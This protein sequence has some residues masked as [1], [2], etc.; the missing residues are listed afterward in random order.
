MKPA[1][2]EYVRAET[3]EQ[4]ADLL[5]R[6]GHEARILAGGQSLIAML[7]MRLAQPSVIVDI[8]RIAEL[9]HIGLARPDAINLDAERLVVGAAITQTKLLRFPDLAAMVPLVA[10][11]LPHVG[12]FQTRNKG[13]VCGSLAHADPSSE[14]PLCMA[15]LDGSV[16]LMRYAIRGNYDGRIVQGQDFFTGLLQTQ[17]EPAE[18]ITGVSFP[19]AK[20]AEG[21]AFNEMSIRH[22]DFALVAVAVKATSE[23]IRIGIGGAADKPHVRDWPALDGSAL[24]D[25]LNALAWEL[26]FQVDAHATAKTRRHLVRTL[27]RRTVLEALGRRDHV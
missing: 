6:G 16:H 14:L 27:G 10:M 22:G 25:A 21:F 20:P 15:V 2:F 1:P 19:L 13:T 11:A 3:V 4:A 12:H 18:L 8:S 23:S 24:D 17:R 9:D 26:E 5:A 7:N